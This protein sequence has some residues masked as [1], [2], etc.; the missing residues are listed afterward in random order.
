[1]SR[2]VDAAVSASEAEGPSEATRSTSDRTYPIRSTRFPHQV[3]GAVP[4]ELFGP[5]AWRRLKGG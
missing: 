4:C 3:S 2:G 1:M 5:E